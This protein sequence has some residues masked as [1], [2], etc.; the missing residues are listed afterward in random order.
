[1]PSAADIN[2]GL[3]TGRYDVPAGTFNMAST[4]VVPWRAELRMHPQAKL[5]GPAAQPVVKITGNGARVLGGEFQAGEGAPCVAKV[6]PGKL[7]WKFADAYFTGLP[8]QAMVGIDIE[9]PVTYFGTVADCRISHVDKAVVLRSGAN[10][11]ELRGVVPW[12]IG[13]TMFEIDSSMENRII[14]GFCHGSG[15]GSSVICVHITGTGSQFNSAIGLVMEP[16]G[17]ARAFWIDEGC[18]RN[19]IIVQGNVA[20]GS[21]DYGTDNLCVRSGDLLQAATVT[22]RFKKMAVEP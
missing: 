1:M 15:G 17:N 14:G 5:I 18:N 21:F 3:L 13:S 7:H 8:A 20:A 4:I 12:A 10:A 19:Q 9:G 22:K 16:G 2:T 11:N 6:E